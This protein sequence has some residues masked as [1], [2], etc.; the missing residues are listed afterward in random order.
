MIVKSLVDNSE[1][2][3]IRIPKTATRA[4][5]AIFAEGDDQLHTH[6]SYK[7]SVEIYGNVGRAFTVIRN[8]IDRLKSG[9]IH[10]VD[11]FQRIYRDIPYPEYQ[12]ALPTD[13]I[14][15]PDWMLDINLLCD[16]FFEA[17]DENCKVKNQKVYDKL[18]W[19]AGMMAEVLKT[20]A[21]AVN[22]PEVK[23]FRY[24]NLAEFNVW[25]KESL[26]LDTTKVPINGPSDYVKYNWLDFTSPRF[27]E[28]AKVLYKEDYEVYGY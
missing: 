7:E 11:E 18:M 12:N 1:W 21:S 5:R 26:G 17:V 3:W 27:I 4:Y 24:E 28:L 2:I 15:Y 14:P 22:Y 6:F 19:E 13:G 20:Q 10:D 9:I 25:I 23:V 8:P 16:L